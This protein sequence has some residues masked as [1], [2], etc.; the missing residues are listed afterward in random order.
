MN[1]CRDNDGA[2][3]L[4]VKKLRV[5]YG[6]VEAVS[7]VSLD[8]REGE[9]LALV[10]ESG[11]GKSSLAMAVPRLLAEPPAEV[12]AE[13]VRICGE[14]VAGGDG[15]ALPALRRLRG[16]VVGTIF[17]D[18]MTALSPLHRIGRQI[19]EA[20]L[21]HRRA[22]RREL[23]AVVRDWLER[24]GIGDP[25]RVA[26]AYP[27]EL[28][29][30]MQQRVMIAMALVNN[31]RLLIADE[32][33]TA[34]DAVTQA[35]VLDLMRGLMD[36]GRAMLLVTHDMGVVRRMATRVAVMYAGRIV[37]TATRDELFANPRHPYT[38]A[39]LASLPTR[40]K[41]GRRLPVIEGFV[42]TPAEC[43]AMPGCRFRPRCPYRGE[44]DG[45]GAECPRMRPNAPECGRLQPIA[46]EGNRK[47]PNAPDCARKRSPE[48]A[49]VARDIR[50]WYPVR[51]GLFSRTTGWVKAVDGVSFTLAQGETLA[52]VGESGSGKTTVSRALLGLAPLHSGSVTL[53]GADPATAGAAGRKALRRS[54]QVVFQD[55]FAS[56]NPRHTVLE[57]VTGAM[58]EQGLATRREAPAEARRLLAEVG[59]PGDILHRLPHEFSGG[60]RQ[61][62][63]I[64]RAMALSPRAVICDEAVSALDLS[65]RAQV[66]NLLLDLRDRHGLS[67]LFITH[68]LA[69]ARHIADRIAVMNG[70][71]IVEEGTPD[72][73][74][75]N[76]RDHNTRR[77]V[78]SA[79]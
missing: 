31:P 69:V 65:V 29:G 52:I 47:Q 23:D 57:L 8:I 79:F 77:L 70:G 42:P 3:V 20:V 63:A 18:P 49:I 10:G 32:P 71:R 51:G 55:P 26:R 21:L 45:A 68:D 5:S 15:D 34:L 36:G 16:S 11:C 74:L 33:T 1:G 6:G 40:E 56:L 59:L 53:F 46:V 78:E 22:S 13:S 75:D 35:Q 30:G 54:L 4:S 43:A 62:I 66:L 44:C 27:H 73:V 76:P 14:E 25:G 64:A 28:S 9:I 39:L 19:S 58:V 2:T 24:V 37:E 38:Q 41:R 67:Y 7:G 61:R 17:Q 60:Q 48:A 50:V 12:A 72:E